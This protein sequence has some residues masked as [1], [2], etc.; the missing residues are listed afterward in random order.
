MHRGGQQ[1]HHHIGLAD[2]LGQQVVVIGEAVLHE[3]GLVVAGGGHLAHRGHQIRRLGLI[4]RG[5]HY[6]HI[7]QSV[8]Q[9]HQWLGHAA[10]AEQQDTSGSRDS[11]GLHLLGHLE[12][13]L[14]LGGLVHR[15]LDQAQHLLQSCLV[16]GLQLQTHA[17]ELRAAGVVRTHITVGHSEVRQLAGGAVRSVRLQQVQHLVDQTRVE[18]VTDQFNGGCNQGNAAGMLGHLGVVFSLLSQTSDV[19]PLGLVLAS[20]EQA[21]AAQLGRQ[22]AH[23]GGAVGLED[24]RDQRQQGSTEVLRGVSGQLRG[25]V[26]YAQDQH[27]GAI[28]LAGDLLLLA[29]LADG[30]SSVGLGVESE[31]RVLD[32]SESLKELHTTCIV[33]RD[34]RHHTQIAVVS[35]RGTAQ[36]DQMGLGE[37]TGEAGLPVD[38]VGK[39]RDVGQHS[40]VE[41]A[42]VLARVVEEVLA[43]EGLAGLVLGLE[44]GDVLHLGHHAVDLVGGALARLD[45]GSKGRQLGHCHVLM[46]QQIEHFSGALG[47]VSAS[48]EGHHK[49]GETLG[50]SSGRDELAHLPHSILRLGP[51][52]VHVSG[53]QVQERRGV[54][55]RKQAKAQALQTINHTSSAGIATKSNCSGG[56]V[57]TV[58]C[59]GLV[60]V[61]ADVLL[62]DCVQKRQTIGLRLNSV[63]EEHVGLVGNQCVG[64]GTLHSDEERGF[65]QVL[66]D[67]CTRLLIL[68]VREDSSG[69][70]LHKN[71]HTFVSV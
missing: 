34:V 47:H 9:L 42:L 4:L 70:R 61:Q 38:A 52:L 48:S 41:L 49:R 63:T 65:V 24:G 14:S 51:V 50:Q 58:L 2:Q 18:Q 64:L 15:S 37:H 39:H 31:V 36:V 57:T 6:L 66:A 23:V 45:I 56:I 21:R 33:A 12:G 3:G 67:L 35:A 22:V 32:G 20:T 53:G 43:V 5:N 55:L 29:L 62:E 60:I 27:A 19:A 71:F 1:T 40:F 16:L 13:A 44:L 25:Q 8:Q 68:I 28:D 69:A 46:R 10:G 17:T 26:I 11:D 59:D 30:V 7:A 54:S